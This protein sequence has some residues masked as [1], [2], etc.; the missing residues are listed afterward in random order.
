MSIEVGWDPVARKVIIY[1]KLVETS[2][3]QYLK[4]PKFINQFCESLRQ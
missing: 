2:V 4:F 1:C 3:F